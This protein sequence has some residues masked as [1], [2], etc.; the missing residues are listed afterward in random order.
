VLGVLAGGLALGKVFPW[1]LLVSV[2]FLVIAAIAA[3]T[4]A[5]SLSRREH[6][7]GFLQ[8]KTF[9]LVP[10][11]KNF[12]LTMQCWMHIQHA[13]IW[14]AILWGVGFAITLSLRPA[15]NPGCRHPVCLA[16]PPAGQHQGNDAQ[17][18]VLTRKFA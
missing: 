17:V 9:P 12:G 15:A 10:D 14:A 11:S 16:Q 1:A 5:S 8:A 3:G 13:G 6:W 7:E 18:T 2:V 4:L